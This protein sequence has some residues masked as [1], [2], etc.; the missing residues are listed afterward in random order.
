MAALLIVAGCTGKPLRHDPHEGEHQLTFHNV[1]GSPVCGFYVYLVTDA[2]QGNNR[3]ETV[4]ELRSGNQLRLWFA[5]GDYQVRATSCSYEKLAVSGYTTN[6]RLNMDGMVVLYR[7]DDAK[8]KDAATR[9]AHDNQ[10]TYL[11]LAK[12]QFVAHPTP[13]T[14]PRELDSEKPPL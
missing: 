3:L 13:R 4:G 2:Q 11:V 10:N 1:A 12:L 9:L 5:P 14:A 6:V 8:S 7:G